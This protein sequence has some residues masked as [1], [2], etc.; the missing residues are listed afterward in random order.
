[1]YFSYNCVCIFQTF[2][3]GK[4]LT[5]TKSITTKNIY[6]SKYITK[7]KSDKQKKLQ[8]NC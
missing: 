2:T 7:W 5:Q 4:K 8:Y 3:K 6:W 1:M